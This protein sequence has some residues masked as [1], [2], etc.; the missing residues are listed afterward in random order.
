MTEVGQLSGRKAEQF[1]QAEVPEIVLVVIQDAAL[2]AVGEVSEMDDRTHPEV[3]VEENKHGATFV[4]RD[5]RGVPLFGSLGNLEKLGVT[6]VLGAVALI[7]LRSHR[8]QPLAE[9]HGFRGGKWVPD[10]PRFSDRC[11]GDTGLRLAFR[12]RR[13]VDVGCH[14]IQ[15]LLEL[16]RE[17]G[18]L[19][20]AFEVVPR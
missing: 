3:I 9:S 8:V 5:K 16:R 1:H 6:I 18:P 2:R 20:T 13:L 7:H 12:E 19:G 4:Q 15:L 11:E 10:C 17:I 14:A